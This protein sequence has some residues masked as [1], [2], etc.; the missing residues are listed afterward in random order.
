MFLH[1]DDYNITIQDLFIWFL[2]I[3]LQYLAFI[4]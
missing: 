1:W 4:P 2:A 3:E